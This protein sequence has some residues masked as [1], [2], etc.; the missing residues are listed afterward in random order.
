VPGNLEEKVDERTNL[1]GK[2]L[3]PTA[4]LLPVSPENRKTGKPENRKTGKPENRKTGKPEKPKWREPRLAW[5]APGA[6]GTVQ[7][8]M[9]RDSLV[10]FAPPSVGC[11]FPDFSVSGRVS[12]DRSEGVAP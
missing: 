5:P 7:P 6:A 9:L 10:V 3:T 1:L 11:F 2:L 8:P 12:A 4:D